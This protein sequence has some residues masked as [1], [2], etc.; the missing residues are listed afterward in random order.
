[1]NVENVAKVCHEVNKSFCEYIGDNSQLSW[2][3]APEWQRSSAIQ[4]VNHVVNNPK[5]SEDDSHK[6]WLKEKVDNGWVYGTVKDTIKKT[7]PCIVNYEDLPKDQQFKD[8]L[9]IT[10]VKSFM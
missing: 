9:F 8:K 2:E 10:I 6:S 7:H 1:M 5:A 3:N 4:G